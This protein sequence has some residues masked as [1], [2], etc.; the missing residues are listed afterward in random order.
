MKKRNPKKTENLQAST[1]PASKARKRAVKPAQQRRYVQV[2]YPMEGEVIGHRAYTFRVSASPAERVEICIDDQE[3]LPCRPSVG[4]W[5]YDWRHF[6][7]G[8]H[9]LR[10]R[11]LSGGK[12][13]LKSKPRQF[14]VHV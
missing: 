1:S 4:Y 11:I 8:P 5:W 14:A 13:D 9:S 12:R 7:T 10:A 3:W 6:G 2:D